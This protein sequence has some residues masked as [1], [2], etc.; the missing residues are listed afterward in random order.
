M[1]QV[2]SQPWVTLGAAEDSPAL[3]TIRSC[4]GGVDGARRRGSPHRAGGLHEDVSTG[5]GRATSERGAGLSDRTACA[6][7]GDAYRV[8]VRIVIWESA[9]VLKVP[10]SALF[11]EGDQWAVFVANEGRARRVPVEIGHRTAREAEV[12]TGLTDGTRGHR[13]PRRP[14][15]R[16][17][18]GQA[19]RALVG[20]SSAT[21]TTPSPEM[22]RR[23][24]PRL[25]ASSSMRVL[26]AVTWP[27]R[28]RV[29]RERQ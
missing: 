15:S 2:A 28:V 13:P 11:R 22:A 8:D 10:A 23:L 25:L 6:S 20:R 17:G 1:L 21:S 3:G 14:G 19:V 7:L 27:T 18:S 29:P 26:S 12:I 5:C 9:D 24:K 16:R 4:S